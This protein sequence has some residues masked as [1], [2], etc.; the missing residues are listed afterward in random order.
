MKT[1]RFINTSKNQNSMTQTCSSSNVRVSNQEGTVKFT[2]P[3]CSKQEITRTG[4]ARKI[5]AKYICPGCGF[6]GPN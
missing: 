3:S 5:A 4:H 2:C 1:K 6:E